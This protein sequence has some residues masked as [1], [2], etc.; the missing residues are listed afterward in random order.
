MNVLVDAIG[1]ARQ[2]SSKVTA[3]KGRWQGWV[4]EMAAGSEL[5]AAGPDKEAAWSISWL[6]AGFSCHG[7]STT[8]DTSDQMLLTGCTCFGILM[9]TTMHIKCSYTHHHKFMPHFSR[10]VE[11]FSYL[12]EHWWQ[13][14]SVWCYSWMHDDNDDDWCVCWKFCLLCMIGICLPCFL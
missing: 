7:V 9:S 8:V 1:P 3:E 4:S 12:A 14:A 10:S 11:L 6:C 13:I 2:F 5:H